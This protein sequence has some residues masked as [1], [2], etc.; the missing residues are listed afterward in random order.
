MSEEIKAVPVGDGHY[1]M[2]VEGE[3]LIDQLRAPAV[4]EAGVELIQGELGTFGGPV[5][6]AEESQPPEPQAKPTDERIAAFPRVRVG[7][8]TTH[9]DDILNPHIKRD[10]SA[11]L[12]FEREAAKARLKYGA[13]PGAWWTKKA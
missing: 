6:L 11:R 10:L 4:A 1:V 3:Q 9:S 13:K 8:Y 2:H 7:Q 12:N 5:L